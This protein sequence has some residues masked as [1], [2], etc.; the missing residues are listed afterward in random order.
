M[1]RWHCYEHYHTPPIK[2]NRIFLVV[3]GMFDSRAWFFF[4]STNHPKTETDAI[5]LSARR[6][7]DVFYHRQF[8]GTRLTLKYDTAP[9][10]EISPGT[11][12]II[13][14][15]I[16]SATNV[17]QPLD[18]A[19]TVWKWSNQVE[20]HWLLA[21]IEY[22]RNHPSLVCPFPFSLSAGGLCTIESLC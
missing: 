3:A 4:A 19:I 8:S 9:N 17:C 14:I 22:N 12:I 20:S 15:V 1:Q 5:F 16:V 21:L 6:R 18:N 13:I 2:G 11:I 10:Y 7:L